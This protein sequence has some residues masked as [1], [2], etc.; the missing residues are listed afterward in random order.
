LFVCFF[1]ALSGHVLGGPFSNVP[2]TILST[3]RLFK[4]CSTTSLFFNLAQTN[5]P[6]WGCQAFST[7][8]AALRAA[9]AENVESNSCTNFSY[10]TYFMINTHEGVVVKIK[11][12][13]PNYVALTLSNCEERR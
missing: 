1:L 12:F 4:F 8:L 9:F 5:T 7:N 13:T 3:Q 10:D 11:F 6:I 2:L